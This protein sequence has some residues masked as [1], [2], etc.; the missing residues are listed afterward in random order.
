M[1]NIILSC[2]IAISF[3]ACK[4]KANES[5]TVAQSTTSINSS[6]AATNATNTTNATKTV[7]LADDFRAL[8]EAIYNK[9]KDVVAA[10][11]TFPIKEGAAEIW[12]LCEK[13][14]KASMTKEEFIKYFD[15]IFFGDFIS[16]LQKVK[17]EELF[18]KGSFTTENFTTPRQS[19]NLSSNYE[20]ANSTLRLSLNTEEGD[21]ESSI[22]YEFATNNEKLKFKRLFIA[23]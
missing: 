6:T 12:G 8:R 3:I 23:G 22:I 17:S 14:G 18:K 4:D 15:K 19:F 11:F 7:S 2:T 1:K 10:Y 20:K 5:S 9:Q 13:E 21:G 16:A